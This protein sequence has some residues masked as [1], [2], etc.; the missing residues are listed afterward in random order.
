MEVN[1]AKP[2]S[3]SPL[4]GRSSKEK[5]KKRGVDAFFFL[6]CLDSASTGT[7]T[8]QFPLFPL[9]AQHAARSGRVHD[10]MTLLSRAEK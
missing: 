1:V 4:I 2:N 10:Y 5:E 6:F 3:T 7:V 8:S 9:I